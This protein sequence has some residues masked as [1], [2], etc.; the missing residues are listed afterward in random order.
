MKT[1]VIKK[2]QNLTITLTADNLR[3]LGFIEGDIVETHVVAD[4]IEIK[5][6]SK[7]AMMNHDDLRAEL[8]K[9]FS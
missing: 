4:T 2:D 9:H 5:R 8:K 7:Y 6:I 1:E 3:T